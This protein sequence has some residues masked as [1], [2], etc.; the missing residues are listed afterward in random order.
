MGHRQS[1][2]SLPP[3]DQ[4]AEGD[5]VETRYRAQGTH[6]GE[7]E[8]FGPPTGNRIDITGMVIDRV[9]GGKIAESW[10]V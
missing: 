8:T 1:S 6:T 7:T 3:K 5:K 4:V 9:G 2:S 10:T